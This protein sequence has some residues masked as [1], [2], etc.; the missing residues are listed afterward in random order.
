MGNVVPKPDQE[1]WNA[2][3]RI[4]RLSGGRPLAFIETQGDG[5]ALMLL[6]G[7][8]D[9]SRS[10]SMIEPS[11]QGL[12]LL[13]PDLPGHGR[14]A[15]GAGLDVESVAGDLA[16][17]LDA[18]QIGAVILVG[19]SMGAMV[20][21]ALAAR[22]G[23]RATALVT[24]SASVAPGSLLDDPLAAS[25]LALA[26]PIDPAEPFFDL[27]HACSQPVDALFLSHARQEAAAIPAAV[28]HRILKNFGVTDLRDTAARISVPVLCIAGGE[29]MLFDAGHRAAVEAAMPMATARLLAGQGHNPH[30]EDAAGTARLIRDFIGSLVPVPSRS[31]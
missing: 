10:Y 7:Y 27:W 5:P 12:R 13:I 16:E 18:R 30:W 21:I 23:P 17:L 29:D 8:T 22:L 24:I 6:H 28:W 26:D 1:R 19:H 11:L 20:A 31:G 25:I 2:R 4:H 14:S 9:S 3:K 15:A